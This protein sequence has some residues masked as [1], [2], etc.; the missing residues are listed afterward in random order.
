M[1]ANYLLR[2]IEPDFGVLCAIDEEMEMR[3]TDADVHSY[4]E[5]ITADILRMRVE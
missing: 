4:R 2:G 5:R 1:F 3:C